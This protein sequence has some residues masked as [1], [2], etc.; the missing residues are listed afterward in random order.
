MERELLFDVVTPLGFQVRVTRSSWELIAGM[1]HPVMR[2]REAELAALLQS[3]EEIRRSRTDPK[4][5]LFYRLERPNRWTCA[6][7]KRPNEEGFLITAYPT[8]A[9]KAGEQ[10]WSR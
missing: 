8:D 2:G 7:V 3:P 9:K 1:K 4:V 6:V 10:I 5:Y